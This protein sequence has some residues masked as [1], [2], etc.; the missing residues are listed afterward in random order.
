MGMKQKRVRAHQKEEVE[1]TAKLSLETEVIPSAELD[2]SIQS[3]HN[4]EA[5]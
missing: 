5:N 4:E 2:D 1:G 3:P